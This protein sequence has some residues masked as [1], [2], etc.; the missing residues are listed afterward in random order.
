MSTYIKGAN[1][2]LPDIK[3]FTPDYKFLSA[4]LDT[5]TDKYDANYQALNNLYNKVVYADL[6]RADNIDKRNQYTSTIA[7]QLEKV[8]GLD[9]SVMQNADM[10]K[11]V[12]AP[13]FEDDVLV[14]DIMFTSA[15]KREMQDA[16]RLLDSADPDVSDKWWDPGIKALNYQMEDFI[17]ATSRS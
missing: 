16:N 5:R 7:P 12:F 4:V 17:N 9:L 14:K 10:A 3:P 6:S 1:T 15:Y 13:F 8:S 11:S 2:Y